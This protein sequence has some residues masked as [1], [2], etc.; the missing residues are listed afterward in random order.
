M[1]LSGSR[2]LVFIETK[3]EMKSR[4]QLPM[5]H[6]TINMNSWESKSVFALLP[7]LIDAT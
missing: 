6:F 3:K 1:I 7:L 5:F 4:L 2:T